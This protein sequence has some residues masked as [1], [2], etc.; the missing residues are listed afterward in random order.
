MSRI[1]SSDH[2]V[3]QR[4]TRVISRLG[5]RRIAADYAGLPRITPI[6][7]NYSKLLRFTSNY[8]RLIRTAADYSEMSRITSSDHQ[9]V[10]RN[11]RVISRLRLRRIAADYAGLPRIT[12]IYLKLFRTNPDCRGLLRNTLDY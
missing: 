10:Q 11:T 9:V 3:V 5:L 2:Q 7:L 1:T 4:N 8:F 6:Y 12:P